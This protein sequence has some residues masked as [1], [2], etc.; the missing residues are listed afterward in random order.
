MKINPISTDALNARNEGIRLTYLILECGNIFLNFLLC[1][2]KYK[3]IHAIY[4]I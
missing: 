4:K 3:K 1:N 2:I